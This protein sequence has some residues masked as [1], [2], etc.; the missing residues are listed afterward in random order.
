MYAHDDTLSNCVAQHY[1][2]ST[3]AFQE[4]HKNNHQEL[5]LNIF[6]SFPALSCR[7]CDK[8]AVHQTLFFLNDEHKSSEA[9]RHE[10]SNTA[11]KR[12]RSVS[13]KLGSSTCTCTHVNPLS[14]L[15]HR[16]VLP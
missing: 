16:F 13:V 4:I 11:T 3:R 5:Q 2:N 15:Q 10:E 1:L 6:N 9:S 12:T 14:K 8:A 7:T